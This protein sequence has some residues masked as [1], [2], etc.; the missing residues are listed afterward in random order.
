MSHLGPLQNKVG[1]LSSGLVSV[2][3]KNVKLEFVWSTDKTNWIFLVNSW[4]RFILL[5]CLHN[6]FWS[7]FLFHEAI[8]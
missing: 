2:N 5:E 7:F 6:W 4:L 3:S 8:N 1:D